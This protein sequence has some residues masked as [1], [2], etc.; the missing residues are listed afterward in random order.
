MIWVTATGFTASS[1]TVI[2]VVG[3]TLVAVVTFNVFPA[4]TGS[5][6][7]VA[8]AL[9]VPALVQQGPRQHTSTA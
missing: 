3:S 1:L 5:C 7:S 4:G 8:V 2:P 9:P 6:P